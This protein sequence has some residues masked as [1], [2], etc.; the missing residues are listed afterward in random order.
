MNEWKIS[1]IAI[2]K[3][4]EVAGIFFSWESPVSGLKIYN[5]CDMMFHNRVIM[6]TRYMVTTNYSTI[7]SK[8]EK[9]VWIKVA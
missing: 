8:K 4:S 2:V 5:E 1:H 3:K 6:C 7:Y 9:E